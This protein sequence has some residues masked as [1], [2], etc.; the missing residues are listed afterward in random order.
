MQNLKLLVDEKMAVNRSYRDA[1][2]AAI[3][4]GEVIA[5][6]GAGLSAPLKYPAWPRLLEILESRANQFAEFR[7]SE[8]AKSDALQHAEEISDHFKANGVAS[9]LNSILGREFGPRVNGSNCTPTHH[10]LVKLPF[11]TF[12][13]TN[14]DG[15][16][17]QALSE[18]AVALGNVPYPDSGI[19]IKA[20]GTDRH[21]ASLFLRSIVERFENQHRYVGY[22][23]GRHDDTD[24][25]IL[26]AS[27]YC[28]AYGFPLK[29]RQ[30]VQ[31]QPVTF[32]RQLTWSLFATRKMVFFGCSMDDPY[33][34]LLLNMVAEDLW[35]RDQATHFVVLPI[36]EQSVTSIDALSTQFQ[37][38]GLQPV[39]FDNCN[40]DFSK[41]DQL[42]DEAIER[43]PA[44]ESSA[45]QTRAISKPP[46]PVNV[47]AV[48]AQNYCFNILS[49]TL[50][51]FLMCFL[52]RRPAVQAPNSEGKQNQPV[53]PD[54]LEEINKTTESSL[55]KDE[56]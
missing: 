14:Y 12:V 15:C 5:F 16:L 35:E 40:R 38:F 2:F 54:W 31:N 7:P 22:L 36:D 46:L 53:G 8:A 6:V 45:S 26:T 37:R 30:P 56:N 44:N 34:K 3:A 43:C 19:I 48:E 24:N 20:S 33:V 9:E 49:L 10:R 55:K 39:L 32:H 27:A 17:E 28:K 23:H 51:K 41:L 1:M 52:G 42:L 11:R 13:T 18:N 21:R 25:I 50:H 4:S 47:R 29:G